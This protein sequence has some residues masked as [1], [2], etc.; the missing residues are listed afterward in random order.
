MTR[1]VVDARVQY[2]PRNV[3]AFQ[4]ADATQYT[5]AYMGAFTRVDRYKRKVRDALWPLRRVT[6][7]YFSL[8]GDF[9]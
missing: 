7:E 5:F 9:G 1:L 6:Y 4:L 2:Y 8:R 3:D